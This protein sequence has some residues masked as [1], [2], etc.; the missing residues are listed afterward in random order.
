MAATVGCAEHRVNLASRVLE[1][2]FDS[3]DRIRSWLAQNILMI[4]GRGRERF[5]SS[6]G[7]VVQSDVKMTNVFENIDMRVE[8]FSSPCFYHDCIPQGTKVVL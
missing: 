8:S 7:A 5:R 1:M 4:I 3:A 6:F 2:A